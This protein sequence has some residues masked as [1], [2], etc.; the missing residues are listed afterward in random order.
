VQVSWKFRLLNALCKNALSDLPYL[1]FA[2]VV[3]PA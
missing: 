1:Q 2:C 3:R